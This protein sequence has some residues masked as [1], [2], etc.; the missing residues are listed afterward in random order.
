MAIILCNAYKI[1]CTTTTTT[2]KLIP[3]TRVLILT[4]YHITI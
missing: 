2:R 1:G 3:M 4:K